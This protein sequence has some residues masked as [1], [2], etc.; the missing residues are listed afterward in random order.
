MTAIEQLTI[1]PLEEDAGNVPLELVGGAY[2]VT[3][4]STPTPAPDL[5]WAQP[6]DADGDRLVASRYQNREISI[7]V[8]IVPAPATGPLDAQDALARLADKIAKVNREG[9]TLRREL[10]SGDALTFDLLT[11]DPID[12]PWDADWDAAA[13]VRVAL[14]FTARPF[15]RGAQE[16]RAV[17]SESTKPVLVFTESAIAGDVPAL[18]RL[19]VTDRSGAD[20]SWCSWGMQLATYDPDASAALLIEAESCTLLSGAAVATVSGSSGGAS[21]NAVTVSNLNP[22]WTAVLSTQASGGGTHRTH[23]GDYRVFARIQWGGA[24]TDTNTVALRLEWALGDFGAFTRNTP[25]TYAGDELRGVYSIADLGIVS[26]PA[27]TSHWEGRLAARSVAASSA[28]AWVPGDDLTVDAL[29]LV[30]IERSGEAR[31]VTQA[32]TVASLT[33]RDAFDYASATALNG[34]RAVPGGT[35]SSGGDADDFTIDTTVHAAKR[36]AIGDVFGSGPTGRWA[37]LPPVKTDTAVQVDVR[38]SAVP[39]DWNSTDMGVLARVSGG[40]STFVYAVLDPTAIFTAT[41]SAFRVG[42]WSSGF[43]VVLGNRYFFPQLTAGQTY[44]IRL[45]IDARGNWQAWFGPQGALPAKPTLSGQSPYLATGGPLASGTD[46]IWE[47]W[48]TSQ[49]ATRY[50]D[51]FSAW[52]PAP[53]A[54]LFGSQSAAFSHD[55]VVREDLGGTLWTPVSRYEGDLLTVPPSGNPARTA[56]FL[57]KSS[58]SVPREGA[59]TAIDPIA[60][61]LTLTPRY[62]EVP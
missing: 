34:C 29:W 25:V 9:G 11:A 19:E 37:V 15:A 53:D 57:V 47:W 60:A 55:G 16:V 26:I 54:A 32:S 56:R 28:A 35:W 13:V 49:A 62:L 42:I 43:P 58:R 12:P 7:D 31:G 51:N 36:T 30:P 24:N 8:E 4:F 14:R 59:D 1:D 23:V 41:A 38:F 40:G 22:V 52:V 45:A 39:A 2:A 33:G 5:S 10:P 17:H 61:Q 21:R 20:Q 6:A 48:F 50:Y 18:A 27:G 3:A 46:G 44:T